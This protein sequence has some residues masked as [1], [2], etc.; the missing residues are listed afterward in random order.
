MIHIYTTS[1]FIFFFLLLLTLVE[2]NTS[3]QYKNSLCG[4]IMNG[5]PCKRDSECNRDSKCVNV[6]C[7]NVCLSSRKKM[8][9]QLFDYN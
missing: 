3:Q 1:K 4:R 9:R 8:G 7:G 5:K 6:R 2:F